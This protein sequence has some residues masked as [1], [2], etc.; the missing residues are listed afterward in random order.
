MY[1]ESFMKIITDIP[2]TSMDEVIGHYVRGLK[3]YVSK[4]LC[5]RTYQSLTTLMSDALSV[6]ASKNSFSQGL[7]RRIERS[8]PE[9][10]DVSNLR[11]Q[12]T[13]QKLKDYENGTCFKC[14][15]GRT[16]WGRLVECEF[17]EFTSA[18]QLNLYRL[19]YHT[20]L[21]A[22]REDGLCDRRCSSA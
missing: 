11:L 12:F 19:S 7:D 3:S 20:T 18:V 6:E 15:C 13:G 22:Q 10:M 9:P 17:D 8:S 21:S 2:N 5:T 14:H 4:E 1:N 16:G